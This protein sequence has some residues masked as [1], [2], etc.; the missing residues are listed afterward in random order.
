MG[1]KGLMKVLGDN[2][3]KAMQVFKL[4]SLFGRK[5][6]IDAS[7]SLYAFLISIRPEN[8][9]FL[10][11]GTGETTSH[12]VGM[13]SRSL[14]FVKAGIK[15]I[16]VFDGTA[17]VEKSD[18]L[19]KRKERKNEAQKNL[20]I[21][22]ETGD[23]ETVRKLEKQIV[24]VTPKHNEEAKK[25]L[26]LMGI[27]VIEAPAEA[28][29]QCAELCKSGKAYA[30]GTEDMDALTLGTT[31]LL[32]NLNYAEA[33]KK[34]I[35]EISLDLVLSELEMTMDQFIDLCILLGCDYCE[36]IKGVGPKRA[37][38]LIKKWGS[39]EEVIKNLDKSKHPIPESF[40]YEKARG[41]FAKPNVASS[42]DLDLE[43]KDPDEEGLLQYLVKEK[44]FSEE[45]VKKGI[46][47]LKQT[48]G[49]AV[50]GRLTDF[51]TVTRQAAPKAPATPERKG[52]AGSPRGGARAGSPA[53][54]RS[55]LGKRKRE[56]NNKRETKRR[57]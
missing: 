22:Q 25:L 53:Q 39:I 21:A 41:L 4:E 47:Q 52:R 19:K 43:W 17:P 35:I 2:C 29:A 7:M 50:Q 55:M 13:W 3:P 56:V 6:A 23:T 36:K 15:P 1:I 42:Q 32:R 40:N 37:I 16:Y 57:K 18:E 34:P 11:D 10:T 24:S 14:R 38:E 28:E 26:R 8:Q 51:F 46:E 12:L 49:K 27:P 9:R 45:R 5:I 30:V 31:K 33:L 48:R 44:G 54:S 20:D